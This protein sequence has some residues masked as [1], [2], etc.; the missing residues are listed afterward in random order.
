MSKQEVLLLCQPFKHELTTNV[1]IQQQF[2]SGILD[3]TKVVYE[4]C[5]LVTASLHCDGLDHEW[6][7]V[8]LLSVLYGLESNSGC[9]VQTSSD[10]IGLSEKHRMAEQPDIAL[11]VAPLES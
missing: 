7:E 11:V 5:K 9:K 4:E 1:S 10:L 3:E 6:H 2:V 8:M